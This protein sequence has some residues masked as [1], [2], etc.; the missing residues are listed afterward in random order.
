MSRRGKTSS[1]GP[2]VTRREFLKSSGLT[3]ALPTLAAGSPAFG[4]AVGQGESAAAT[5]NSF[6]VVIYGATASGVL[7]AVA[8]AK[9]GARV[10]LL[11]PGRHLG[12]MVSGGLSRTDMER[13]ENLIGGLAGEFF[14]RVGRHYNRPWSAASTNSD[15]WTFEPH[16]AE[17]IFKNWI[18]ETGPV[19][20]F[21]HRVE[22]VEKRGNHI[23]SLKTG[24][25]TEFSAK[26]FIDASYEGDLMARA[27]VSYAVG[28]EGRDEFGESHAGVRLTGMFD[29]EQIQVP[30][31]AYDNQQRLLPL[32]NHT[33]PGAVGSADHKI[34]EYNFR[35]C[36]TTR[37]S[38]QVPFTPPPGYDPGQYILPAL[39]W[40]G[41]HERGMK[42]DFPGERLPNDKFDF[43]TPWGGVGL[44]Y[45]GMSWD[46]PDADY[47]KRQEIWDAHLNYVKGFFY[48][49]ANDPSVPQPWRDE[50]NKYGLPKDEFAD[51]GHWSNQ[52][53][54]REGRRMR[55]EYVQRQSDLMENRTK[56]D[57]IGMGGYNIDI[58]NVERVPALITVFPVGTKYIAMNEGYMSIPVEAYQIPYRALLPL[59]SECSNLLVP[60]CMSATHV[61]YG[62]HR[63]EPQYMLM[64]HAAGV[65]AAMAAKSGTAVQKVDIK[66]LQSKLRSQGQILSTDYK[67]P[68]THLKRL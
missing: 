65:A 45:T 30:V 36:L 12:G 55:G 67:S 32:M 58:L 44:N 35:V 37:K 19:V 47:K 57:S 16:V 41:M 59:Y 51:T 23:A 25:G 31:P 14:T 13:Q 17:D 27:G 60:V 18:K 62:S 4:L 42:P 28:R 64:G 24:S 39:I 3:A 5:G 10:A 15:D 53:Y 2:S 7:A 34:Q 66:A 56:Y 29:D 49:L 9:E 1:Q 11:E 26:V 54:I 20:H 63:L 52:L 21:G 50:I 43:N 33:E 68:V 6:D 22:A 40:K 61:A 46:Y 8:A 38:N 48:F